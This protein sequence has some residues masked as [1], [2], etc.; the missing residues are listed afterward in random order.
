MEHTSSRAA[1]LAHVNLMVDTIVANLEPCA[2]RTVVRSMLASDKSGGITRSLITESQNHLRHKFQISKTPQYFAKTPLTPCSGAPTRSLVIPTPALAEY[3]RRNLAIL[4]C[5]LAFESLEIF[6]DIVNQTKD[7]LTTETTPHSSAAAY[8]PEQAERGCAVSNDNKYFYSE[9]EHAEDDEFYEALVGV[10]HELVQAL[11]AVQKIITGNGG[12][13]Q[14]I[15]KV[16][17]SAVIQ[18]QKALRECRVQ[19]E[20]VQREFPLERAEEMI[21]G[22]ACV[23][24]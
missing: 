23:M 21:D 5:G 22:I 20:R 3:R 16:Q 15:N 11:T 1:N 24:E 7:V 9:D 2:L 17:E 8:V 14:Q 13:K 6:T 10:D 12:R 19:C 18:L 4:G